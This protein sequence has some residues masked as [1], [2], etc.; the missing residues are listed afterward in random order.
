MTS[1]RPP[2]KSTLLKVVILG[3]R[4]MYEYDVRWCGR[5]EEINNDNFSLTAAHLFM[6][7]ILYGGECHVTIT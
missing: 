4:I 1:M 5:T 3:E 2:S 6:F 7:T